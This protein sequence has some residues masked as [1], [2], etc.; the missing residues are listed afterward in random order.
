V[1]NQYDNLNNSKEGDISPTFVRII[2]AVLAVIGCA[3]LAASATMPPALAG[4]L[5]PGLVPGALAIICLA[6]ALAGLVRPR[7]APVSDA[8]CLPAAPATWRSMVSIAAAIAIMALATRP[9]GT[10]IAVPVAGAIAALRLR[11]VGIGRA[12]MIGLG[13]GLAATLVFVI[14]LRQPLPIWPGRW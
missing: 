2:W 14:L 7:A 4:R 1:T 6:M 10:M 9:L 13:L 12:A 5:H 8:G 11:D 3:V